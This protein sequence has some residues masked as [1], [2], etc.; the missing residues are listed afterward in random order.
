MDGDAQAGFRAALRRKH[1]FHPGEV[2]PLLLLL[3]VPLLGSEY[4]ALGTQVIVAIIFALSLDLLVGYAGVVTLGHAVFFG[5]GAYAA[6]IASVHGWGEPL[7][8]LLIGAATAAVAGA[9]LGAVVLRTARFTLLM[10]TLSSV[11]L[12]GEVANKAAWVTGGVDGLTGVNTWP[13]LGAFEFDLFGQ[14]GY[15]YAA[16]ALVLAW[17]GL[18][19]LVH[20][21]FGQSVMAMRDNPGRAAAIG[22]AVL[23][24]LVLVYA[25]STGLAGLAGALQAE[26]NQFVGLKDIGFELSATVLVM[27]ALGGAGRLYGAFAGPAAYLVAQDILAKDNP[28]LWQLWLGVLI[29]AVVLF[30]PGG[31]LGIADRLGRGW[32]R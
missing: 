22:M 3:A 11:F 13:L 32:R 4:Y 9:L 24:R 1:R 27:L 31:I 26:V 10:L 19:Y 23:P 5:I 7:S 16:V 15:A 21:P 30:A 29:V 8:G 17:L 25:I 2:L 14:V 12:A 28:V 20:A 6:G 18:R